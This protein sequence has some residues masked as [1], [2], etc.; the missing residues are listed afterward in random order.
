MQILLD[1]RC[2][3]S[4]CKKDLTFVWSNAEKVHWGFKERVFSSSSRQCSKGPLPNIIT[5]CDLSHS[6]H[7][8]TRGGAT[9]KKDSAEV[10]EPLQSGFMALASGRE[11]KADQSGQEKAGLEQLCKTV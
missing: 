2:V 7:Q 5:G 6:V 9:L 3:F 10:L 11:E 1:L 4:A 8:W